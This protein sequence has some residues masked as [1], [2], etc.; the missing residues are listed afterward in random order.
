MKSPA[1][2]RPSWLFMRPRDIGLFLRSARTDAAIARHR[3]ACGAR[4]AFEAAYAN[5]A[6][7]WASASS[8]Y[9]YQRN[10]YAGLI[11]FLPRG[12]RF[13]R[14]LDLGCGAGV[15]SGLLAHIG[16]DVLGMDIAQTAVDLAR[17][18]A[19]ERAVGNVRFE[20]GDITALPDSMDGGFDLVVVADTIYYLDKTDDASL[21][22]VA[23]RV[24]RLLAPGG[25]CMIANHYF[26]RAD[27]D[28]RLSRRIHDAFAALAGLR[29]TS[30][31]RR[32]FYIAT[33]LAAT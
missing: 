12:K 19:L 10:K 32:A 14:V 21:A 20:Q 13:A 4:S 15:L 22:V 17:T 18:N 25:T 5:N 30:Q 23:E 3:A 16:D 9:R 33:L 2:Q 28:S 29:V 6:D 11:S 1:L 24:A 27:K 26:F 8:R 7:P 31:H